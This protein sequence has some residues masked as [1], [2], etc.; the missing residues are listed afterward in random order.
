MKKLIFFIVI[1]AFVSS[2]AMA[3]LFVED[4][5]E[6]NSWRAGAFITENTTDHIQMTIS[7]A[8]GFET[9]ALTPY[10]GGLSVWSETYNDGTTVIWDT[11]TANTPGFYIWFDDALKTQTFTVYIQTYLDG[12]LN[13]L[14]DNWLTFSNTRLV[15][16]GG[17]PSGWDPGYLDPIALAVVPVPGAVLLGVLGLSAAGLKLRKF[18]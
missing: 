16:I 17:P 4:Y 5:S 14:D 12:Q 9:P 3:G 13:P 7:V 10:G 15:G 2:P 11:T 6:G 1:C 18:A 8:D